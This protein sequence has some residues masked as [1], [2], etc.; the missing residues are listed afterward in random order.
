MFY[1][2]ETIDVTPDIELNRTTN[3]NLF[4]K[5]KIV[6]V[7]F[8]TDDDD[9]CN[10]LNSDS[11]SDSIDSLLDESKNQLGGGDYYYCKFLIINQKYLQLKYDLL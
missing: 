11:D 1:E 6:A 9:L 3:D 2:N 4:D 10:E 7:K 5:D 8:L